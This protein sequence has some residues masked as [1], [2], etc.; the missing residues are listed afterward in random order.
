MQSSNS[1]YNEFDLIKNFTPMP[2]RFIAWDKDRN[3]WVTKFL[4]PSTDDEES[5]DWTCPLTLGIDSKGE[6]D[7]LNNDQLIICQ[8]TNL[9]DK[10]GNEIFEGDIIKYNPDRIRPTEADSVLTVYWHREYAGFA[11]NY[12]DEICMLEGIGRY[13]K[14]IGHILSNPELLEKKK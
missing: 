7:W 14:V 4:M 3:D 12:K 6:K 11:V 2:K 10:D 9:F 13:C 1:N 5:D 8:S